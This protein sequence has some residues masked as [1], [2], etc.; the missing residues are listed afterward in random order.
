MC[1]V[2]WQHL[3]DGGYELFVNRDEQRT[4]AIAFGPRVFL[5]DGVRYIAPLDAEAGGTW[6]AV[7]EY[8]ISF[9][10]LN[11]NKA[12]RTGMFRSRGSVIPELASAA[13][14]AEAALRILA[15][16]IAEVQP[17]T[18]AVVGPGRGSLLAEWD[19]AQRRLSAATESSLPLTSSSLDAKRARA[20][21]RLLYRQYGSG[22]DFHRSHG[23]VA[24]AFSPC[25]HR[26]DAVTVSF[27]SVRVRDGEVRFCYQPGPPCAPHGPAE[28]VSLAIR[29]RVADNE[30]IL[31]Y[32]SLC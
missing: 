21:R 20:K 22:A 24:D 9:T 13:S 5:R 2:S 8:G 23:T 11:G 10:V 6:L 29:E 30:G 1:T 15:L 12:P 7:N 28:T 17:F 25:M 26:D 14:V 3:P 16:D 27:S 18:L 19:G 4:R 32:P 31:C